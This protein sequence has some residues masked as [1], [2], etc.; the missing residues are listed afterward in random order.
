MAL[1]SPD[2]VYYDV[3]PPLRFEGTADVRRNF[4]RWFDE[5]DGGIEL[6]THELSVAAGDDVAF[7]HMLHVDGGTRTNGIEGA[8]WIRSTVCCRRVDV[9]WM[10][11][12]EHIS[13]PAG[14][15][16]PQEDERPA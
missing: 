15:A 6:D 14:W 4:Q 16:A 7:A 8:V 3:V 1:Y 12:H 5:Y 13:I 11:T 2:I 9:T 10:I